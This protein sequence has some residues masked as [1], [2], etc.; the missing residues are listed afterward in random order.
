[1]AETETCTLA[2]ARGMNAG[3]H[4][5]DLKRS[6][7]NG[8]L[9]IIANNVVAVEINIVIFNSSTFHENISNKT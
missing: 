3:E 1:M 8:C 2:L 7:V 4:R 6:N 9:K 5:R